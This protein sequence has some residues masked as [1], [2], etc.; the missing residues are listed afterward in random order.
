M[1]ASEKKT[2]AQ[3]NS[4]EAL[5]DQSSPKK[6]TIPHYCT[7]K[8][9]DADCPPTVMVMFPVV[10]FVGT[11]TVI[12]L[13]THVE[14]VAAATPRQS[15]SGADAGAGGCNQLIVVH[16]RNTT[17]ARLDGRLYAHQLGTAR[18]KAIS[19]P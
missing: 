2:S 11:V 7:V 13:S 14:A 8:P 16:S 9:F 1:R 12:R 17:A 15:N 4:A 5:V 19:T 3:T 6:A 18:Y 10:A